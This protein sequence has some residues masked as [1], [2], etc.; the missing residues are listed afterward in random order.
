M[1]K[2]GANEQSLKHEYSQTEQSQSIYNTYKNQKS[3][4]K[5]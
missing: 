5:V 4:Y 2:V 3:L 1:S